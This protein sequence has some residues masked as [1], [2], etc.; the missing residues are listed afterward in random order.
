MKLSH[1][2]SGHVTWNFESFKERAIWKFK[3]HNKISVF[4]ITNLINEIRYTNRSYYESIRLIGKTE[5]NW[6]F[7]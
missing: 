4:F 2:I 7:V 3:N 6:L 5:K 1:E